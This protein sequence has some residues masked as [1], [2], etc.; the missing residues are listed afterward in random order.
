MKCKSNRFLCQQGPV[1]EPLIPL[2]T[3]LWRLISGRVLS[4]SWDPGFTL[5]DV[6]VS[7]I[8]NQ[9]Y[10]LISIGLPRP[11]DADIQLAD[12]REPDNDRHSVTRLPHCRTL[13][14]NRV[15]SNSR[16]AAGG[17]R[18]WMGSRLKRRTFRRSP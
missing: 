9:V 1:L 6:F 7:T 14:H 10:L 5:N 17:K 15:A 3:G 12:D 4:A 13:L 11:R 18:V 2:I 8:K 16:T